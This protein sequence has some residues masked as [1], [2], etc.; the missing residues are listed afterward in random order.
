MWS[1]LSYLALWVA[2]AGL[3]MLVNWALHDAV[4][5]REQSSDAEVTRAVD[6]LPI[7]TRIRFSAQSLRT[8]GVVTEVDLRGAPSTLLLI[9]PGE[10]SDPAAE[11]RNYSFLSVGQIAWQRS[12]GRLWIAC[13][14]EAEQCVRCLAPI[15]GA[16]R[17]GGPALVHEIHGNVSGAFPA[18]PGFALVSL[19]SDGYV[20]AYGVGSMQSMVDRANVIA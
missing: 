7:G 10:L 9:T 19:D 17:V 20:E 6:A 1:D 8:G 3:S 5:V 11:A 18:R 12:L 4:W 16:T 13:N 15:I 14:G 2:V